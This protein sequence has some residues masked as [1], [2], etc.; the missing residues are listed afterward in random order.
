MEQLFRAAP[1]AASLIP[2]WPDQLEAPESI[3][4]LQPS[5]LEPAR[6]CREVLEQG[7]TR[8]RTISGLSLTSIPAL[9]I[10][11][12]HSKTRPVTIFGHRQL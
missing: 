2:A 12:A 6:M 11:P 7:K 5:P 8:N 1:G 9:L 4:R 3:I 10:C